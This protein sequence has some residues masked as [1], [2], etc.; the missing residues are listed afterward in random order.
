MSWTKPKSSGGTSSFQD[1]QDSVRDAWDIEDD[2][3][4]V[5]SS[6]KL[7][8]DGIVIVFSNKRF[9]FCDFYFV[10]DVKISKKVAQSTALSVINSHRS[11]AVTPPNKP[12]TVQPDVHHSNPERSGQTSAKPSSSILAGPNASVNANIG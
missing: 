1:F 8:K 2:E 9:N 12:S 4:S 6:C 3:F 10:A 11:G 5:I 7:L